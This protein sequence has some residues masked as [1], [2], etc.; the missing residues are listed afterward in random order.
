MAEETLS[1]EKNRNARG[2]D[3]TFR[4]P[5]LPTPEVGAARFP[6]RVILRTD[7]GETVEN[8]YEF[9]LFAG[10]KTNE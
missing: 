7:G 8:D 6:V 2:N 9:A 10:E 4:I 1:A 5:V 3:V